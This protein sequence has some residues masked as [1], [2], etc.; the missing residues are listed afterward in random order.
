MQQ[1]AKQSDLVT[2]AEG[3]NRRPIEQTQFDLTLPAAAPRPEALSVRAQLAAACLLVLR[4]EPIGQLSP[5]QEAAVISSSDE[6][7]VEISLYLTS[8]A[9]GWREAHP[10]ERL[11]ANSVAGPWAVRQVTAHRRA[12]ADRF[13]YFDSEAISELTKQPEPSALLVSERTACHQVVA[14]RLNGHKAS[15][16]RLYEDRE[17]ALDPAWL[18]TESSYWKWV[19]QD[20]QPPSVELR[21]HRRRAGLCLK[22]AAGLARARS[23]LSARVLTDFL[24]RQS[25]PAHVLHWPAVA[26]SVPRLWLSAADA[27]LVWKKNRL[28]SA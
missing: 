28:G 7:G 1:N 20:D 2:V 15:L 23:R 22:H 11:P 27:A 14:A 21:K 26:T 9:S 5:E 4:E 8:V 16:S 6:L 19:E 24:A 25:I 17:L 13:G 18:A 12:A 3:A 10:G